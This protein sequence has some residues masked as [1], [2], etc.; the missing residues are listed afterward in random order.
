MSNHIIIDFRETSETS[1]RRRDDLEKVVRVRAA[2]SGVLLLKLS[3]ARL[4]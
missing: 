2:I 4:I 1:F 3:E